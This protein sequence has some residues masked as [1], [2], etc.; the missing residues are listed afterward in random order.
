MIILAV[1]VELLR[2][3]TLNLICE[4]LW[5]NGWNEL[6]QP[7][8]GF[9]YQDYKRTFSDRKRSIWQGHQL[10][11]G[12]RP[13]GTKMQRKISGQGHLHF[14][15]QHAAGNYLKWRAETH[16]SFSHPF[17]TCPITV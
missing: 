11:R 12:C 13:V 5:F 1:I 7:L 10:D 4:E 15:R 9:G 16:A 3:R 2:D 8:Y 17:G 14:A 6:T